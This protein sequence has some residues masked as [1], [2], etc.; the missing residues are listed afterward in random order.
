MSLTT[1]FESEHQRYD[2]WFERHIAT[3]HSELLAVRALLPWRGLGLS[4]GVGSGRFAAPLGVQIGLDP[5]PAMLNYAMKRDIS[6]VQ[7]T[8]EALPFRNAS[9]HYILSVTTICFV[10][11]V[12]A[13]L[14]EAKRVL[15]LGGII[16]L[17]FIDRETKLGQ[18]YLIHQAEN[19]FYRQAT[20][21]SAAEVERLLSETGFI[22][23]CWVQTLFISPEETRQIEPLRTGYGQGAFVVVRA[24][25]S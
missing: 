10:D 24:K 2:L 23:P 9:F 22:Q 17:G 5:V 16:V 18:R 25:L 13:M 4:I 8:A 14:N 7:A 15:K 19:V 11:D 3:Y 20:F 1:P 12:I 21:Y 6:A